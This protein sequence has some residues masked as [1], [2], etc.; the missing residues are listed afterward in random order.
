[1]KVRNWQRTNGKTNPQIALWIALS[2]IAFLSN[3]PM[4]DKGKE[5][6]REVVQKRKASAEINDNA[7]Y[8]NTF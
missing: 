7:R 6:E 5:R 2:A 3:K 4:G 8:L 1:M